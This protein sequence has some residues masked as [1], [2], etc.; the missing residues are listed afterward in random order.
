MTTLYNF[1]GPPGDAA[2]PQGALALGESGVL[3]GTAGGGV[4]G[5]VFALQPPASPSGAWTETIIHD[6]VDL[7]GGDGP[8]GGVTIGAHGELYGTST[9]GGN[10]G[11]ECGAVFQLEPPA[12]D[13]YWKENVLF[14][15]FRVY[16]GCQPDGVAIGRDGALYGTTSIGG[17]V[18]GCLGNGCGTVFNLTP[19]EPPGAAWTEAAV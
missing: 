16:N 17:P 14:L 11:Y 3:Y 4:Y 7:E 1:T 6:F 19:P 10:Y 5:T 15:G 13:G 9:A 12:A 2:N 8:S 18:S